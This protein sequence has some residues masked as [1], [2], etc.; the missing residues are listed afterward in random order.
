MKPSY[1]LL[2]MAAMAASATVQADILNE[3]FNDVTQLPGWVLTNQSVPQ[4]QSWFQGNPGIFH[5]H[6]GAP[7]A[8]IAANYVSVQDG[9]GPIDNWLITPVL[10]LA[11]QSTLSFY[12]R[13]AATPGFMDKLEVR[14]SNGSGSDTAG[15]TTL[16]G[17]VGID[18]PYPGCWQR[19]SFTVNATGSGRFAL[20]YVGAGYSAD[21]I[22]VDNLRVVA[23][24]EPATFAMLGVG[25][26]LLAGL[27]RRE[28]L[29]Y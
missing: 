15:F 26:A 22:G 11:G 16:L 7:D 9:S 10:S 6:S 19:V 23:V 29:F 3:Q 17:S 28:R 4:G 24:P 2:A 27:R 21:Y 12:T 14:F 25:L 5:A 1:L 18:T 20:R 8:Y 13:D